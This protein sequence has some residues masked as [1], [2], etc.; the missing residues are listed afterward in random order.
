M[1]KL[2]IRITHIKTTHKRCQHKRS[3]K[4]NI[5]LSEMLKY[6][7]VKTQLDC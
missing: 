6:K 5:T 2:H 3:L 1:L 7:Q 4:L